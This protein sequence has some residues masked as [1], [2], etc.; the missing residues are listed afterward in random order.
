[1]FSTPEPHLTISGA[2]GVH[3]FSPGLATARTGDHGPLPERDRIPGT[4]ATSLR[5]LRWLRG[6]VEAAF[7]VKIDD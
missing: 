5:L 7:Y 3:H 1:V 4:S 2:R 6:G